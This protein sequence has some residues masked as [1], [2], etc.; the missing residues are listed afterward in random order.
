MGEQRRGAYNTGGELEVA[1]VPWPFVESPMGPCSNLLTDLDLDPGPWLV[2]FHDAFFTQVWCT[3]RTRFKPIRDLPPL[4]V[5]PAATCFFRGPAGLAYARA[6]TADVLIGLRKA[7][8]QRAASGAGCRRRSRWRR[9]R[10]HLHPRRRMRP[11]ASHASHGTS[12]SHLSTSTS[13]IRK[14]R[15]RGLG[16]MKG[17]LR[18]TGWEVYATQQLHKAQSLLAMALQQVEG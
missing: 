18:D 14:K 10:M 11:T 5:A 8:P 9:T 1:L 13:G 16:E 4:I 2:A 7:T 6:C 3:Y 12:S 17:W 15:W